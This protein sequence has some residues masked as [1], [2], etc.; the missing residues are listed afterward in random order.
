[1]YLVRRKLTPPPPRYKYH[2][3]AFIVFLFA[4]ENVRF[5]KYSDPPLKHYLVSL[6]LFRTSSSKTYSTNK[7]KT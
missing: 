4:I 1:M 3:G 2:P 7:G 5:S 6:R